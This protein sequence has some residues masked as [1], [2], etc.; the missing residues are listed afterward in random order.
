MGIE[1]AARRRVA[2]RA[3]WSRR[4]AWAAVAFTCGFLALA[5][6]LLFTG[7]GGGGFDDRIFWA[8]PHP[9]VACLVGAL[10]INQKGSH[11]VGWLFTISGL[12]WALYYAGSA[13]A[14]HPADTTRVGRDLLIWSASWTSLVGV[15][16]APALLIHVFPDGHATSRGGAGGSSPRSA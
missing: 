11:P 4:G 12:V 2:R 8:L 16:L 15:G 10:V 1:A 14:V 3:A 6:I 9:L 13:E 5:A 7:P